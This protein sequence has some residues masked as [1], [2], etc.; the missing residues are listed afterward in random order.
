MVREQN[1]LMQQSRQALEAQ[2]IDE[3]GKWA[4]LSERVTSHMDE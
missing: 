4:T 1:E 2:Y 3:Q